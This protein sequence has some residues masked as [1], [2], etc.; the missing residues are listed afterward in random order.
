MTRVVAAAVLAGALAGAVSMAC[1]SRAAHPAKTTAKSRAHAL[2]VL[3]PD[4]HTGLTGSAIVS[5]AYGTADLM[6]PWAST[7]VLPG[8]PPSAVETVADPRT[9]VMLDGLRAALPAPS[10]RFT[11]YFRFESEDASPESRALVPEVLG[12]ARNR[13]DPEIVL[14]GHTDTAGPAER[15]NALGLKRANTV[16]ALLVAA[17]V[18]ESTIEV[19]SHGEAAPLVPTAD[20]VF[21]P[22]NRRV[23]ITVR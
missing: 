6:T 4:D 22:R 21:E 11:M 16:K 15:N 5:N 20:D 1:A 12:A 19:V 3:L 18:D 2:V 8:R 13:P 10:A 9:R 23:E 7:R 14:T 17:H